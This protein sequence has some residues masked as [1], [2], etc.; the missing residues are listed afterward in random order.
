[1]NPPESSDDHL[2]RAWLAQE[3]P[4]PLPDAGFTRRVLKALPPPSQRDWR[5]FAG[6]AAGAAIGL[7]WVTWNGGRI[8]DLFNTATSVV[9]WVGSNPLLA[10][11]IAV[12]VLILSDTNEGMEVR[13]NYAQPT[14]SK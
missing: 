12:G 7:C 13:P 1:M 2:F 6:I 4:Q 11:S 5:S 14:K 10:F 3:K 8:S 9:N